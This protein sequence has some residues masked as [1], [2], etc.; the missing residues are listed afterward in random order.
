MIKPA[1]V[2]G[3]RLVTKVVRSSLALGP[4]V[5]SSRAQP[6]PVRLTA[7][8]ISIREGLRTRCCRDATLFHTGSQA[9]NSQLQSFLWISKA[10]SSRLRALSTHD[11]TRKSRIIHSIYSLPRLRINGSAFAVHHGEQAYRSPSHRVQ[12]IEISLQ[13]IF[14]PSQ[15]PADS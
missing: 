1:P 15:M 4:R 2:R 9:S 11:K 10:I 5:A 3:E 13:V 6:A 12:G 14:T 7:R 8:L